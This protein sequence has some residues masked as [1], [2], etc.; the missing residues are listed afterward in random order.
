VGT[1]PTHDEFLQAIIAN[2]DDD[3]PR[4]VYADWLDE[5][6]DPRGE[7]IR[8]QCRLDRWRRDNGDWSDQGQIVRREGDLLAEHGIGWWYKSLRGTHLDLTQGQWLPGDF[9]RG[10]VARVTCSWAAWRDGHGRL[11][12]ATPLEA[13]RL[14]TIPMVCVIRRVDP[15]AGRARWNAWLEGQEGDPVDVSHPSDAYDRELI[16]GLLRRFWPRIHFELPPDPA[17]AFEDITGQD[18]LALATGAWFDPSPP[19]HTK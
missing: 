19:D 4:L 18:A 9:R 11:R 17:E 14:T 6:G 7:F 1:M 12:A 10:F 16:L 3:G 5:Q 2:R 15:L 13:V 8:V